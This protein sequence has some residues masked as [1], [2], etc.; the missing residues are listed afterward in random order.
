MASIQNGSC[1]WQQVKHIPVVLVRARMHP[2]N[3]VR[4]D[5]VG[6]SRDGSFDEREIGSVV[7]HL[8]EIVRAT[9]IKGSFDI[10][11]K[12]SVTGR[13]QLEMLFNYGLYGYGHSP[14]FKEGFEPAEMRIRY[15][16]FPRVQ[17]PIGREDEATS[18][19]I[20]RAVSHP[21]GL[22]PFNEKAQL[23]YAEEV[24][25]FLDSHAE[26]WKDLQ[27][28]MSRLHALKQR[29]SSTS[30]K[31]EKMAFLYSEIQAHHQTT[32]TTGVE[33]L[34]DDTAPHTTKP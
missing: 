8:H 16:L 26:Q 3:L 23:G 17:P 18:T 21:S 31:V 28:S 6:F 20:P 10:F 5:L 24:K 25:P 27:Q 7:F 30:G 2:F 13:L 19:L 11:R 12:H 1:A 32:E 14:Q 22:I 29:Y 34:L 9:P 15:S 33:S 4:M